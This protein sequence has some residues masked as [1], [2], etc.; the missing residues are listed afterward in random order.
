MDFVVVGLGLGALGVLLGV[1]LF[2]VLAPLRERGADRAAADEAARDRAIA[3][4]QREIGR[5]AL[6]AGLAI[7]VATSAA[8]AAGLDDRTGAFLITSTVTIAAI[9]VLYWMS[10]YRRRNPLPARARRAR[11]DV[12]A[13]QPTDPGSGAEEPRPR[14]GFLPDLAFLGVG[15]DVP[16][17][18]QDGESDAVVFNDLGQ[19]ADGTIALAESETDESGVIQVVAPVLIYATSTESRASRN[20]GPSVRAGDA[21]ASV[22][23]GSPPEQVAPAN[24]AVAESDQEDDEPDRH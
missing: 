17:D 4:E 11:P 23:V 21:A 18:Q 2:G 6:A 22:A 24:G 14:N 7:L 10:L 5:A 13:V 20:N 12:G 1:L 19:E 3:A 16:T 9:G 8:L 15:Q